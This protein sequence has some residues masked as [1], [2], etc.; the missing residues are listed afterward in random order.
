MVSAIPMRLA[1]PHRFHSTTTGLHPIASPSALWTTLPPSRVLFIQ[2]GLG[3]WDLTPSARSAFCFLRNLSF[4]ECYPK[5]SPIT[6]GPL[7]QFPD[8]RQEPIPTIRSSN[9]CL[10]LRSP[11]SARRFALPDGSAAFQSFVV[12]LPSHLTHR[13]TFT[14]NINAVP[15]RLVVRTWLS[16]PRTPTLPDQ[17]SI[18]QDTHSQA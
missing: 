3:A 6:P 8:T 5:S 1:T 9:G 12:C 14:L 7:H 13:Q 17:D 16:Q 10:I 11:K 2:K 15:F 4:P 18:F